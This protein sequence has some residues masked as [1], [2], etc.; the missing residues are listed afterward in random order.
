MLV[1]VLPK[2][3][4]PVLFVFNLR[5]HVIPGAIRVIF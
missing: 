1:L 5:L 4:T 2:T 3:Y